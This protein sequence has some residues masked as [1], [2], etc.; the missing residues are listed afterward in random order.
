MKFP[1]APAILIMGCFDTKAAVYSRLREQ[2]MA[3]GENVFCINVG[4]MGS[5]N[6]FPVDLEAAQVAANGGFALQELRTKKDRGLALEVMAKGLRKILSAFSEQNKLKGVIAMGGGGG[7][8]LALSAMKVLPLG[9]PKLCISTLATKDVSSLVG[10]KDIVLIPS[11]VDVAELNSIIVPII[12]QAAAAIVAMGRVKVTQMK[13]A[14]G[15]IAISMFGN[16]TACVNECT[17]I[18]QEKGF[19]VMAFHANG[20]GGKTMEALIREGVFDGVLDLTTTELADELCGGILSAGP[21]RLNA[22]VEMN[23]PLVLAP[24]CLDMVNFGSKSSVPEQYKDRLFYQ[25]VPD[26]TLMRTN[27]AENMAM[28]KQIAKKLNKG[29]YK[30]K[31][32]VITPMNGFSQLDAPGNVFFDKKTTLAFED[33]LSRHLDPEIATT[34]IAAN[35]NEQTFARAAVEQL[36]GILERVK[37]KYKDL[38]GF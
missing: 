3:S 30:S 23:L 28:A 14:K 12:D 19:E 16:T 7:T 17:R 4:I 11:V 32:T 21:D 36:L 1:E 13:Q 34:L 2:V 5:T 10:L 31:I 24:G 6:I 37:P 8:F 27:E 26:V 25:W 29:R 20:L 9:L 33:A 22:A 15:V 35:I 18:L 38:S